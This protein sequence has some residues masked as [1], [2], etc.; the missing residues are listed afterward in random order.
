[1]TLKQMLLLMDVP[2]DKIDLTIFD[3]VL[4]LIKNLGIKN[5]HHKY[6]GTVIWKLRWIEKENNSGPRG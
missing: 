2:E 3:N 1:M 4:W 5:K 6:Y